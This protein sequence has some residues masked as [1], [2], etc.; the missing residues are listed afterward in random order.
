M[1][2]L[3]MEDQMKTLHHARAM[4]T[5]NGAQVVVKSIKFGQT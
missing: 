3:S 2:E 1:N 4:I 5:I